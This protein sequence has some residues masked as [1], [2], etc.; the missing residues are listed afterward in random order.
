[1]LNLN[2]EN[3][4][5]HTTLTVGMY[6]NFSSKKCSAMFTERIFLFE[7]QILQKNQNKNNQKNLAKK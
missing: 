2:V 1:M 3:E 4:F 6:A 7:A 5:L